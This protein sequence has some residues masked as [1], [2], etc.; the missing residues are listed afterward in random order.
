M[1]RRAFMTHSVLLAAA[2]APPAFAH[3]MRTRG[4]L[5]V[6]DSTLAEGRAL[7]EHAAR[8]GLPAFDTGEDIGALW[9]AT[10]APHVVQKGGLLIGVTRRSDYFVLT[11]FIAHTMGAVAL[12]QD[13]SRSLASTQTSHF[14][15]DCAIRPR[16][17][18]RKRR[19]A[20]GEA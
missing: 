15:I 1:D 20:R 6:Y 10:L 9:Y 14:V 4:T 12:Q 16:D 17:V 18:T 13:I 5:A 3:A 11:Q 2:C 7:A 19:N 8:S